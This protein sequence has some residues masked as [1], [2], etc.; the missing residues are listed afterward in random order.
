MRQR[1]R[2][3]RAGGAAKA[4]DRAKNLQLTQVKPQDRTPLYLP[5]SN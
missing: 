1:Q 5:E 3:A 4:G 2:I